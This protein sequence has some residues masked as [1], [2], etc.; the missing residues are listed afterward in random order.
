VNESLAVDEQ[1]R[2]DI[3]DSMPENIKILL[4]DDNESA[5]KLVKK[6]LV[7]LR[8]YEIITCS[9]PEKAIDLLDPSFDCIV[10]DYK[11]P[12]MTGLDFL[13]HINN[14][15][16]FL[17]Y[18]GKGSE[19]IASKAIRAGVDNYLKKGSGEGHYKM[20]A[21]QIDN[22]ISKKKTEEALK[23][24][25]KRYK[26]LVDSSPVPIYVIQ[27]SQPVYA[28]KAGLEMTG[29]DSE[30][31]V[32]DLHIMD[33]VAP[34]YRQELKEEMEKIY[35]GEET[36]G[37]KFKVDDA[38]GEDMWVKSKGTLITF[39]GKPAVQSTFR[40]ITEKH[41]LKKKLEDLK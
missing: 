4:V 27:D 26:T 22:N 41:R 13:E 34:E 30:D 8:D 28:N 15:T 38:E 17:L 24:A 14:D 11:M 39:N 7:K 1:V 21:K 2:L 9:D 6:N 35:R 12:E 32:K 23:E 18:T 10:C 19:E 5:L 37:I 25:K 33:K 20:L 36:D 29:H 40:D 16:P 3:E 31:E